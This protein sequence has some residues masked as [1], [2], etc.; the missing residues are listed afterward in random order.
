MSDN[1]DNSQ[2]GGLRRSQRFKTKDVSKGNEV[3]SRKASFLDEFPSESRRKP[4]S[5][6]LK[7]TGVPKLAQPV[8]KPSHTFNTSSNKH[9]LFSDWLDF[10]NRLE[11]L[12]KEADQ[13]E[14]SNGPL[15]VCFVL[16]NQGMLL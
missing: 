12:S 1:A 2:Q 9:Y 8:V 14:S 10:D 15:K 7:K 11:N 3:E 6:G 5:K 13:E 16:V 4:Q